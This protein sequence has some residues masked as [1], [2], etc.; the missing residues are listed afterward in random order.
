MRVVAGDAI[1]E[2]V[3]V[4]FAEENGARSFELRD[5]GGVPRWDEI[6]QNFGAGSGTN[7]LGVNVV[8]QRDGDAVERAAVATRFAGE[9]FGFGSFGLGKGKVGG[10]SEVG[11]EF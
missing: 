2:L 5:D 4:G 8:L 1:G 6:L 7:V 3:H 10:H 11:V 9:K